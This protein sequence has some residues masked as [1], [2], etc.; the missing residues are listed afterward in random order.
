MTVRE[1]VRPE[2]NG[3]QIYTLELDDVETL[4]LTG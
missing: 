3:D 4:V 2:I 1:F